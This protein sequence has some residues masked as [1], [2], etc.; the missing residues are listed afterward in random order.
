MNS[1]RLNHLVEASADAAA[2]NG[3]HM[4]LCAEVADG[5][6]ALAQP[7]SILR[8]AIELMALPGGTETNRQ[9]YLEMSV[10]QIDRAATLFSGMQNLLAAEMDPVNCAQFDLWGQLAPLIEDRE[11]ALREFGIGISAQKTSLKQP[12]FGDPERTAQAISV[13]LEIAA[14]QS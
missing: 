14:S 10:R 8:S 6:H 12:V 1:A 7:L 9:R 5:L 3:E 4:Q 2:L 13:L 11:T